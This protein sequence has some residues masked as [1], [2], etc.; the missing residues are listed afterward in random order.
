MVIFPKRTERIAEPTPVTIHT[1]GKVHHLVMAV[2]E[3][4][5]SRHLRPITPICGMEQLKWVSGSGKLCS[6][7]ALEGAWDLD[8]LIRFMG[9]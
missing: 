4:D 7:G 1:S 5:S 2:Q 8:G 9:Y 3:D 6:S